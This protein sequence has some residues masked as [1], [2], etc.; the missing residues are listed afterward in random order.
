MPRAR[1]LACRHDLVFRPNDM[2]TELIPRD[3]IECWP[4]CVGP[5]STYLSTCFE[6]KRRLA[7]FKFSHDVEGKWSNPEHFRLAMTAQTLARAAHQRWPTLWILA[8]QEIL[9]RKKP[10]S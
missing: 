1:A 5:W 8:V 6:Q 3:G 10:L 4:V 2:I 9:G 7:T